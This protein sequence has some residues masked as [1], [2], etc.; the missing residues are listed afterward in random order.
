MNELEQ[1][2]IAANSE[3]L[4]RAFGPHEQRSPEPPVANRGRFARP[5][6]VCGLWE[7]RSRLLV[8]TQFPFD[9]P[10]VF[11]GPGCSGQS[12]R[13]TSQ[14][15][16]PSPRVAREGRWNGFEDPRYPNILILST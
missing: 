6:W 15:P 4:R 9:S 2:E 11:R 3:F 12:P 14:V 13:L 7:T 5:A 16:L 8:S 10:R 1:D